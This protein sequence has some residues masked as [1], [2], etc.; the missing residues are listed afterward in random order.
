M[1]LAQKAPDETE[2]GSARVHPGGLTM[3]SAG[4]RSVELAVLCGF[5]MAVQGAE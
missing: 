4:Q 5:G 2:R 1:G 3:R